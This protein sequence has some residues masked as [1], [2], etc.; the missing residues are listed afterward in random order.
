M[1]F[2]LF[3]VGQQM[4]LLVKVVF[5]LAVGLDLLDEG[6]VV[7]AEFRLTGVLV[8]EGLAEKNHLVLVQLVGANVG[9]EAGER[10]LYR[11]VFG[12]V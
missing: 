6:S 7:L 2:Y 11:F 1:S 9:R 12:L 10:V 3:L 8:D 5:I 4:K